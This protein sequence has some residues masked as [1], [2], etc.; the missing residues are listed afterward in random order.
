MII[1]NVSKEP[2]WYNGQHYNPGAEFEVNDGLGARYIARG[3]AEAVVK[4]KPVE[5]E[6]ESAAPGR[7][8]PGKEK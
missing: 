8:A 4:A 5:P 1:R 6:R 3:Q 2:L 7:R